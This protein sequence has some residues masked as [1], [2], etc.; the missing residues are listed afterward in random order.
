VTAPQPPLA[1]LDLRR[2]R[3][4][5]SLIA[6]GFSL[7]FREFR[8]FLAIAA[9]VVIPVQLIVGGVGLGELTS[10]YNTKPAVAEQLIPIAT[11]FLIIAPLTTAMCIYAMLDIAD[12]RRP[13]AATAIQRGLDVFAPLLAV[14]LMYAAGVVVG[15]FAVIIPGIY[16]L[17]RWSFVIQATV[18]DGKRG[19]DA[20]KRSSELVDK[21]WLRVLGVTL[22]ANLL[23]G[24]LSAIIG[25]PFLAAASS[26]NN[27]AFQLVGTI[28]GGVLFAAPAAIITTL[29][30]FD[31]RVRKGA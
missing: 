15:F 23:V 31:Q 26:T 2:Q 6:D 11:S 14:M 29:L 20:L 28:I 4:V 25:L 30:Y 8:T 1:P 10:D 12:G 19:Y 3:D 27:A 5:G 17:V 24:G 21:S 22:A 7:Y 9:A 18:V 13:S 16:L